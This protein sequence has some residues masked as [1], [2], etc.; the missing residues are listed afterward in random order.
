VSKRLTWQSTDLI[1][2]GAVSNRVIEIHD[3]VLASVSFSNDEAQLHFSPAYIHQS[4]GVPSHD[5]GSGWVQKAILHIRGASMEGAF[6]EFPV[7][8]A[9]GEIRLEENILVNEIPVPLRHSGKF[10]LRLEAM[11]HGQQVVSFT[12]N[13]AELELLGEAKYVE[14]FRP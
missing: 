7:E 5:A 10:G 11:W 12:G 9:D 14:E 3:S 2:A 1:V 8:L 13:G 4:E 6:S